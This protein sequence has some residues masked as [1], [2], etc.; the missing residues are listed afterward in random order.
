M[1][2][3]ELEDEQV[4]QEVL[5]RDLSELTSVLKDATFGIHSTVKQQNVVS[6]YYCLW[7]PPSLHHH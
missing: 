7:E 3:K 4:A 5:L 2:T 6:V 1:Y